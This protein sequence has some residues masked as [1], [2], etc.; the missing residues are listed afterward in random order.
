MSEQRENLHE[1]TLNRV[2]ELLQRRVRDWQDVAYDQ[3]DLCASASANALA[4]LAFDILALR[5]GELRWTTRRS[6]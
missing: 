1:P 2:L 3:Q 5:S 4:D 6:T